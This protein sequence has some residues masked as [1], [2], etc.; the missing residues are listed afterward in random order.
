MRNM[1][2]MTIAD[3][4]ALMDKHFPDSRRLWKI[5]ALVEHEVT[6]RMAFRPD[7]VRAGGTIS[8][9]AMM[10]LADTAAYFVTLAHAG[11]LPH[12]ATANLDIHF[13]SR[14]KPVDILATAKLLRLGRRLAISTVEIRSDGSD[15]IVAHS[16]VT[17]A[18]PTS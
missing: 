17:Y 13:L 6:L 8:G 16:T 10:A 12:M 15:E 3:I 5:T 2:R 7:L 14:P 1:L 4:E 9:P 18:L 11:P